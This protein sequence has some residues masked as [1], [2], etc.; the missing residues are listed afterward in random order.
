MAML[1]PESRMLT[2]LEAFWEWCSLG[3]YK[4]KDKRSRIVPFEPNEVQTRLFQTMMVL[5]KQRRPIRIIVLKARKEGVST[6][7]QVLNAFLAQHVPHFKCRTIAHTDDSTSDIHEITERV[8]KLYKGDPKPMNIGNPLRWD[9]D[10]DITTRTA[11][12]LHVSSG[13]NINS[14][15]L[16]ELAKWQNTRMPISDQLASILQSVPEDPN[17]IL[18]IESTASMR[19]VSGEFKKR[20]EAAQNPD[21]PYVPF[22]SPWAEDSGYTHKEGKLTEPSEY[23]QGL[24]DNGA[25]MVGY[26]GAVRIKVTKP[27]VLWWRKKLLGDFA[28]DEIYAKQEYPSN[29]DEA[30]QMATGRVFPMLTKDKHSR[31]TSVDALMGSGYQFF[32]AIDFGAVD[33][34]VCIWV[35][36]LRGDPG[37][38]I[39]PKACPESWRELTDYH[40]D[41]YGK[42]AD[43]NNHTVDAI[44]YA[45]MHYSLLG[46]IHIYREM[47]IPNAASRNLSILDHAK[48]IMERTTS[49]PVIGTVADRSQPG[50][51][52]LM[53]Q[54]G[55]PVESNRV[56]ERRSERGEIMDGVNQIQAMMIASLPLIYP[57]PPVPW[58]L[59]VRRRDEELGIEAS[60]SSSEMVLAMNRYESRQMGQYDD[61]HGAY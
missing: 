15:H 33:P 37:F 41:D 43:V 40:Y 18:I 50:S 13:A 56:P 36:H 46:H 1:S 34:F 25:V 51:I 42:P 22:F 45:I 12:G 48:E 8:F 6:L 16:S 61:M 52:S 53:A 19:D 10:S 55:L 29:P 21:S 17:T 47:Y 31:D 57:P 4:I 26:E 54:Q 58:Q 44:R 38:T 2:K 59:Q 27:Q 60:Y 5:A 23:E 14:L 3:A 32:R 20:W 28:G 30:F 7:I 49:E 9:H 39:D 24:L 35:A 11:G